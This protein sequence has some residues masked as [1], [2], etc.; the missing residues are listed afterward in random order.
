[1]H[2]AT[3][4]RKEA[5]E[6]SLQIFNENK[7]HLDGKATLA[8]QFAITQTEIVERPHQKKN[9]DIDAVMQRRLMPKGGRD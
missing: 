8:A 5:Q 6:R 4:K 7:A 2:G 9:S 1:M 3:I